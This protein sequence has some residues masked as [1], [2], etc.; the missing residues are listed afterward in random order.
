MTAERWQRIARFTEETFEDYLAG[1]TAL[2]QH[3]VMDLKRKLRDS[4][5]LDNSR[6]GARSRSPPRRKAKV[7]VLVPVR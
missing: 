5:V 1:M 7:S 3:V 2:R 4:K 6:H